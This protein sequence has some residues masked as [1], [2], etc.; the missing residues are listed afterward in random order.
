MISR[1]CCGCGSERWPV[2]ELLLEGFWRQQVDYHPVLPE[3]GIDD[4]A[5]GSCSKQT[6]IPGLPK[7]IVAADRASLNI[8]V[9]RLRTRFA[10]ATA[11]LLGNRVRA[12]KRCED[13]GPV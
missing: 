2:P 5:T 7:E 11:S 8:E 1:P 4:F 3:V 9:S 6:G 13:G 10:K 12:A